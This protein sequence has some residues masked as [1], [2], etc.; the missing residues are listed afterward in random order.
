MA[1]AAASTAGFVK[2][3]IIWVFHHVV[4]SAHWV[5]SRSGRLVALL[6]QLAVYGIAI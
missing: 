5:A 6:L 2:I 4:F 3:P 1:G